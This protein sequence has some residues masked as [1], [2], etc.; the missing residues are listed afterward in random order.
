MAGQIRTVKVDT[1]V[2]GAYS[3]PLGILLETNGD[4]ALLADPS[5]S[6]SSAAG[7]VLAGGLAPIG[8]LAD[9]T[10]A[11]APPPLPDRCAAG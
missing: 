8:A 11:P 3:N 4:A 10:V 6:G 9:G 2:D 7:I 1:N 5:F